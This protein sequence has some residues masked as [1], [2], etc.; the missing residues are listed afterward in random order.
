MGIYIEALILYIL[1][2]L[3]GGIPG[4]GAS[5]REFSAAAECVKILMCSLPSLVL[6]WYL[7][8]KPG[9]EAAAANGI[10]QAEITEKNIKS[11][12][13]VFGKKDVFSILITLPCL[14]LTGLLISFLSSLTGETQ[15]GYLIYPPSS[16]P[17]WTALCISCFVSAYLEES[18]FRYYLLSKRESLK[19]S[20]PGV[21][22]LSVIL[23]SLCHSYA[24]FFGFLNALISG[25]FL[26]F[27]FLKFN[28]LHGI[29]VS[30]GLYNILAFILNAI[31]K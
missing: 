26:C 20:V 28:A 8:L 5:S 24:G 6:V 23:F 17:G 2:F 9:G 4:T 21:F 27:I 22:A 15:A 7:I 10:P 30:H 1:L 16:V 12:L 18:Y 13:P 31:Y 29:A 14:I 25:A 11:R 3:P 19:L